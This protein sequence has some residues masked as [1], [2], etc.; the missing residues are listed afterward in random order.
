MNSKEIKLMAFLVFMLVF[1]IVSINCDN[2]LYCEI[3]KCLAIL[4]ALAVYR[5]L[6]YTI[7][8]LS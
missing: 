1:I 2:L 7:Q 8:K 5:E 6:T 4:M 3:F